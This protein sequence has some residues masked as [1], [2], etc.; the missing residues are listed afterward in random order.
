M[1]V[2]V[3]SGKKSRE[4]EHDKNEVGSATA[5]VASL[6]VFGRFAAMFVSGI[7]FIIVARLLGPSVYG[8]YVLAISYAGF[9][10]GI[11]D[12]GVST[13][14]NKFIAQYRASGKKEDTE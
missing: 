14:L 5:S 12:L 4:G 2:L 6:M 13:A 9:F 3:D 11:A 10:G 1:I 8:I 7:T